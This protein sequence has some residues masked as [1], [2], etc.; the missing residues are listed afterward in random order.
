MGILLNPKH[1]VFAQET[2]K[3]LT[4]TDAAKVAGFSAHTAAQQGCKLAK[5]P[6]IQ[7]RVIELRNQGDSLATASVALSKEWVLTRLMTLEQIAEKKQQVSA[8]TRCVELIGKELG[9]FQDVIPREVFHCMM[10]MMGQVVASL[11]SDAATLEQII[12]G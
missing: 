9:M 3:G 7:K 8:A 12:A 2:V 10:A 1:E 6:E 4:Q 5:R 11:V